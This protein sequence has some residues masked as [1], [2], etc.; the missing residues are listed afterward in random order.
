MGPGPGR[1]KEQLILNRVVRWTDEGLEYEADPR[2]AE[3]AIREMQPRR[4]YVT[5]IDKAR[6]M[7]LTW[8]T[9]RTMNAKDAAQYRG[10]AARLNYL[11]L[12]RPDIAFACKEASR[13]MSEPEHQDWERLERLAGYLKTYPRLVYKYAWQKAGPLNAAT[14]SDW[15]G[16]IATRKS[17]SG[18]YVTRGGHCIKA[19]AKTQAIIALSTAEAELLA[20]EKGSTELMGM[21][22]TAEDFGT[23]EEMTLK[24]D[25]TACHAIVSRTG[26]GRVRHLDVRR[27]WIQEKAQKGIIRCMRVS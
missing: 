3:I 10:L 26:V 15:A 1:V 4:G 27:L 21:G 2:H 22:S 16:C 24:V 7:A 19:W 12:D 11:A 18:G 9:G 14:D 8:K 5:P 17:T 13:V 23:K 20:C 25:A 6:S